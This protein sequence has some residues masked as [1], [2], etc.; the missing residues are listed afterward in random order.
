MDG[1]NKGTVPDKRIG[2]NQI[3]TQ[4]R[5]C[6]NEDFV[7]K[8]WNSIS[9]Y[10]RAQFTWPAENDKKGW[11]ES[12]ELVTTIEAKDSADYLKNFT[13]LILDVSEVELLDLSTHLA[14][15]KTSILK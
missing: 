12:S 10:S 9:S 1:R 13:V 11:D 4:I 2:T 7:L 3:L 6:T 5:T 8:C 14:I 15:S